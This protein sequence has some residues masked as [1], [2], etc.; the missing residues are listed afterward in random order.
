M[1]NKLFIDPTICFWCLCKYAP[2]KYDRKKDI[3]TEAQA[4]D[5]HNETDLFYANPDQEALPIINRIKELQKNRKQT[6]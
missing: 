5:I 2:F 4:K 3:Y 1:C 6:S